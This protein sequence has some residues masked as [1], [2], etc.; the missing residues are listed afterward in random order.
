MSDKK[1]LLLVDGSSY[2]YRAFFAGGEAMST[3]LPDGTVQKTGAIRIMINMVQKLL[4][5]HPCTYAACVFDA[6][7][8]TF[9]D[10]LYPEY[11]AQ[12]SP[13]PDDLRS[14][15]APIHEVVRLMGWP[16]LDVPGVE[17]DDVIGTLAVQAADAGM[18]VTISTGD[19]DFAQLVRAP[20]TGAGSIA[21]VNTMSGSRMDSDAAVID[22]FGVPAA[23]IVDLLALMGDTVDNVPGV[24]KCGPRP[25]P[26][27]WAST[28]RWMRSSPR[29]T[30]SRARSATTCVRRC[31]GCRST[32]SW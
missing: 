6:K 16:V 31:R 27:G 20:G 2:L 7:G 23:R 22:K 3:T 1:T 29:P 30:R 28:A 18:D 12:R 32:A 11:K 26:S 9:R 25:R 17:A 15:I 8:P 21:L 19:K 4:K 5:D 14:Q 13:M 10:A 24:E